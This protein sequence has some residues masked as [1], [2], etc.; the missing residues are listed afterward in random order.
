[1][2]GMALYAIILNAPNQ[3]AWTKVQ[4]TWPQHHFLDDRLAFVS[5]ENALTA[6]IARDAGIG[7]DG[8]RGIVIQMDYF[9]GHT[10]STLVEWISKHSD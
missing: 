7:A 9:H 5:V 2:R 4:E 3:E 1:M 6:D 10:T 8:A